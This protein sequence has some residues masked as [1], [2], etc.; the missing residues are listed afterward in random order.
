[1]ADK[2]KNNNNNN[3]KN[4]FKKQT[5]KRRHKLSD[6][7]LQIFRRKNKREGYI[8]ARRGGHAI[9]AEHRK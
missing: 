4:N 1:M 7:R 2:K 3:L 9:R 8:Y 6:G 5:W